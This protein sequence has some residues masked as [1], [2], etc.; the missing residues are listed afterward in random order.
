MDAPERAPP[1]LSP[2]IKVS[3]VGTFAIVLLGALYLG[4][5]LALPIILGLLLSLTFM[6]VIRGLSRRGVPSGVSAILLVAVFAGLTLGASVL[7]AD[8]ITQVIENAPRTIRAVKERFNFSGGTVSALIEASKQVEEMSDG[9]APPSEKPQKVVIAQP[10]ILSWAADTLS[11]IGSTLV[12]TFVLAAFLMS[13][14]DMFLQKLVRILPTLRDKKRSVRIVHDIESEVSRYLLTITVINICFGAIIGLAMAILGMP[15]P[16]MWG[17]AATLLNYVP[18]LGALVAVVLVG[19]TAIVT[20]PSLAVAALPPLAYLVINLAEGTVITPLIL[21]RRLELN[22]VVIL[23]ALALCGWLW[24]VVGVL[25]AVPLLVVVRVICDHSPSLAGFG[26]F[27]SG[28][29]PPAEAAVA[30]SETSEESLAK[31]PPEAGKPG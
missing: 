17:I 4:R 30:L 1:I 6:P 21:G 31:I 7:L 20:Y 23:I 26:E 15:N 9:D 19:A 5:A 14:G 11:G 10:G 12:A 3:I 24:G 18:Y 16:V 13:S 28:N 8:P 27:L 25:I 2:I 29:P 22:A